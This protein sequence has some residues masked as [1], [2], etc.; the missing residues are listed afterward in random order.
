M[1]I[2]EEL[3]VLEKEGLSEMDAIRHLEEKYFKKCDSSSSQVN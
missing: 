1:K 3:R 2:K